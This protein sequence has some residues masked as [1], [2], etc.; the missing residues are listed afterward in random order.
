M[1]VGAIMEDPGAVIE[2]LTAAAN[3][4]LIGAAQAHHYNPGVEEDDS[5]ERTS[6]ELNTRRPGSALASSQEEQFNKPQEA[7]QAPDSPTDEQQSET[8]TLTTTA[9]EAQI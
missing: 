7:S 8:Q 4:N 1:T 6:F 9:P 2:N 5:S 3:L